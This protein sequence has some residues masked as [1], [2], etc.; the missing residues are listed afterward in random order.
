M[1]FGW[2]LVGRKGG[3]GCVG[4]HL[5]STKKSA[6]DVSTRE[7]PGTTPNEYTQSWGKVCYYLYNGYW[8]RQPRLAEIL[9]QWVGPSNKI[10]YKLVQSFLVHIPT[11]WRP[12]HWWCA[13]CWRLRES[14]GVVRISGD[15]KH[16]V[17]D[18]RFSAA[19]E[20]NRNWMQRNE[21]WGGGE[22]VVADYEMQRE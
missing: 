14:E 6:C 5:K 12:L 17:L 1:A 21:V 15:S 8:L 19:P 2:G 3:C 10:T 22:S 20:R 11:K 9:I 13:K 4:S 16:K 18:H 7:S